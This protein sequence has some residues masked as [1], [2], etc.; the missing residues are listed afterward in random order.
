MREFHGELT[1]IG[2]TPGLSFEAVALAVRSWPDGERVWRDVAVEA[3]AVVGVIRNPVQWVTAAFG[4]RLAAETPAG[5]GGETKTAVRGGEA[6]GAGRYVP[7][8]ER[9][10]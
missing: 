9:E 1:R 2:K 4:R 7:L 6:G 8:S 3:S 10:E 5:E